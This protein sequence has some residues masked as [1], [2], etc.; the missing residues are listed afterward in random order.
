MPG[1][2]AGGNDKRDV[3]PLAMICVSAGLPSGSLTVIPAS[4][5]VG[6]SSTHG[7]PGV[8]LLVPE[9]RRKTRN[10]SCS[11]AGNIGLPIKF[12]PSGVSGKLT[13]AAAPLLMADN[14]KAA[15]PSGYESR[16]SLSLPARTRF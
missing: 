14:V 1:D 15:E 7:L 13:N 9:L 2:F 8:T 10:S 12:P 5:L 16:I 3:R 11:V 4:P 6:V